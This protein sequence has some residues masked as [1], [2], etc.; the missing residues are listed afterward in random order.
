MD[1]DLQDPP[2]TIRDL[3]GKW[4]EGYDLVYAQRASRAAEPW[5]KRFTSFLFY[6]VH[7][8]LAGMDLPNDTGDFRLMDR[9]VV[10]A[11]N[12]CGERNRYVR[13]LIWWTG[14][15]RTGIRF[16]R[17]PRYGG[18]T[19]YNYRRLTRLAIDSIVAF[20]IVPLRFATLLGALIGAGSLALMLVILIQRM[21]GQMKS[22]PG[23]AL[24]AAGMLFLCRVQILL[25]GIIG[26]PGSYGER[27][28]AL[29]DRH[30]QFAIL[31][32]RA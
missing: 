16:D 7:R 30:L 3:V 29:A 22:I 19:K 2:E 14:F 23:Y 15:R 32:A 28:V 9:R 27:S 4:R 20:S 25:L 6:R 10:D 24:L 26:E 5:H 17:D 12:E 13:G 31:R 8:W 18:Q 21:T 1:A 11:F